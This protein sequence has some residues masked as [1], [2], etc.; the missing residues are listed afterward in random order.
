MDRFFAAF[1]ETATIVGGLAAI[2]VLCFGAYATITNSGSDVTLAATAA[3]ATA[4][5]A[6]PYCIAG[7]LHRAI[8]RKKDEA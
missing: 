7:V 2:A 8:C 4:L 5:V 6:V 1:W 3:L